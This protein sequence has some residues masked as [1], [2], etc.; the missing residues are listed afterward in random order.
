MPTMKP[1]APSSASALAAARRSNMAKYLGT[2]AVAPVVISSSRASR[3][4]PMYVEK[5]RCMK[6]A[7]TK[8]VAPSAMT[9]HLC[10]VGSSYTRS[11][12]MRRWQASRGTQPTLRS[13][14]VA[15]AA[16]DV[17]HALVVV[18]PVQPATARQMPQDGTRL[19]D[20]LAVNVQV[21]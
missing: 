15:A 16:A 5:G 12:S 3:L 9:S 21:R 13:C 8:S 10:N 17:L 14:E 6:P 11:E 20:I 19:H 7:D 4:A 18:G 1:E 2:G